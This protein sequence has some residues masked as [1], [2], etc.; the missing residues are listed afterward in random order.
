[1][2]SRLGFG[3]KVEGSGFYNRLGFILDLGFRVCGFS[4]FWTELCSSQQAFRVSV[5]ASALCC[6][7]LQGLSIRVGVLRGS[8]GS[9]AIPKAQISI[10]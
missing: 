2:V 9:E 1:M 4:K 8:G 5:L 3:V 10:T 7:E 6:Y